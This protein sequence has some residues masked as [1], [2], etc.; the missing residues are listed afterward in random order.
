MCI[1]PREQNHFVRLLSREA[2]ISVKKQ[3]VALDYEFLQ[4]R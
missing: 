1:F 2:H 3:A 4:V